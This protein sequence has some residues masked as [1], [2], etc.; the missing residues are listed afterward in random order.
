MDAVSAISLRPRDPVSDD[1]IVD[2]SHSIG[3]SPPFSPNLNVAK[4]DF[5][6][7]NMGF[8]GRTS[9]VMKDEKTKVEGRSQGRSQEGTF[10]LVTPTFETGK[11]SAID[12]L[13]AAFGVN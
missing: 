5:F 10:D 8:V 9:A 12:E 11:L 4:P 7:T 13:K 1:F 2:T 6:E 3:L